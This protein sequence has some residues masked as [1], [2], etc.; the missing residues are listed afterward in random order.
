MVKMTKNCIS[1]LICD[2][3]GV[4]LDSESVILEALY[5]QLKQYLP[6][7]T[8]QEETILYSAITERVGMMTDL[9]IREIN[10]KF[11]LNLT[12]EDCNSVNSGVGQACNEKANP[13][14]GVR[15]AISSIH[16][17]RAVASNSTLERI[18]SGLLRGGLLDLFDGHIHSG[19]DLEN[20][21]PAPDVY[22]AAAAGYKAPLQ[23]CI[24]IEDSVIGVRAAA[25]AGIRVMGF[26]G[27]AH[28]PEETSAKLLTA[29]AEK[30]FFDM[31]ELAE[32]IRGQIA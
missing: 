6:A 28:N 21:K 14:L 13:V 12:S 26:T 32:V 18:K 1:Y 4:L 27:V 2:C 16:L 7:P 19:C 5:N 31:Q 22:L 11:K 15:E 8:S 3:D 9:L 29:G 25:A 23:R 30:V 20:P 10:E 24:A 17:P